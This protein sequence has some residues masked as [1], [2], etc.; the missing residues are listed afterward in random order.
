M[1]SKQEL[2]NH[3]ESFKTSP[4][5]TPMW[6]E[7]LNSIKGNIYASNFNNFF[8]WPAIM[9]AMG[10]DDSRDFCKE[11]KKL[12]PKKWMNILVPEKVGNNNK[13]HITSGFP[14]LLLL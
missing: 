1:I 4:P 6:K 12:L 3:Y 2:I 8:S 5:S 11:I 14:A 13:D 7:F 9:V 10:G